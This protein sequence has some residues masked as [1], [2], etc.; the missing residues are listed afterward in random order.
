MQFKNQAYHEQDGKFYRFVK[1]KNGEI[2]T[3]QLKTNFTKNTANKEI[4]AKKQI[5]VKG[6]S[7]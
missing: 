3:E 4:K 1:L 6:K 7:F 5:K 2:I